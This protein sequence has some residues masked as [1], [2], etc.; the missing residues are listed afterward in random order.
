MRAY[1]AGTANTPFEQIGSAYTA[2]LPKETARRA[3]YAGQND[4][5]ERFTNAGERS[6]IK[7]SP[8]RKTVKK[9]K[10]ATYTY[11]T[12]APENYSERAA[13][14]KKDFERWGIEAAVTQGPIEVTNNQGKIRIYNQA[15]KE[16]TAEAATVED[17]SIL[18]NNNIDPSLDHREYSAHELLH[19]LLKL[20]NKKAQNF[21]DVV[22][23]GNIDFLSDEFQKYS[24]DIYERYR[25]NTDTAYMDFLET[26]LFLNEFSAFVSGALYHNESH[27]ISKHKAMFINWDTVVDA[28]LDMMETVEGGIRNERQTGK[29]SG[30]DQNDSSILWGR[31]G[32]RAGTDRGTDGRSTER[33]HDDAEET[34]RTPAT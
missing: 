19:R 33:V 8:Q 30:R 26:K 13:E 12:V 17:G 1:H 7:K 34:R 31:S 20:K 10:N 6:T 29:D 21:Y 2:M 16:Y 15:G 28:W 24:Y 14:I 23:D 18:I 3:Y 25:N 32:Q 22:T 11:Q 4:Q 27:S 9:T 5:T